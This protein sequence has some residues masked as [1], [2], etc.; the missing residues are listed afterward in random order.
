MT[1][2]WMALSV[3]M[4]LALLSATGDVRIINV[5]ETVTNMAVP[6]DADLLKA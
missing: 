5:M 4:I 2:I 1:A 3:V 6:R